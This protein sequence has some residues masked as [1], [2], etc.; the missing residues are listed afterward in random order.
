MRRRISLALVVVAAAAFLA[1]SRCVKGN[2][3]NAT[4]CPS[5]CCRSD[6]TC[7]TDETDAL[8]GSGG[9]FCLNCGLSNEVCSGSACVAMRPD[10]GVA[11]A[12]CN[13]A[14]YDA[15]TVIQNVGTSEVNFYF[16]NCVVVHVGDTVT[17][18]GA[19]GSDFG[20]HPLRPSSRNPT[21][22]IPSVSSGLQAQATFTQ[23]GYFP[24]YCATHG[25]D[26]GGG[27]AGVV[28]VVP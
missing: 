7:A 3:C 18:Q 24:F 17:W 16:P 10:G 28:K 26:S 11:F 27:M 5:G 23:T 13:E 19:P 22:P 12:P 21:N 20:M 8:C 6:D 4:T 25:D 1:G 2:R 14:D 15:G 9:A